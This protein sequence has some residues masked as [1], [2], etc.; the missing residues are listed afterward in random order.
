MHIAGCIYRPKNT[1][2]AGGSTTA[3]LMPW[4]PFITSEATVSFLRSR[5]IGT[6][7]ELNN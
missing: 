4:L 6:A 5:V 7:M 3:V 1:G 2:K